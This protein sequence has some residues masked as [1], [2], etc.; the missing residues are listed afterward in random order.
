MRVAFSAAEPLM[1]CHHHPR[2]LVSAAPVVGAERRFP[3]LRKL[4]LQ[5]LLF[6]LR[7]TMV[8]AASAE[9]PVT[10]YRHRPQLLVWATLVAGAERRFQALHRLFRP[11]QAFTAREDTAQAQV[12]QAQWHFPLC[13]LRRL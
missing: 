12:P 10:S 13:P 4:C 1:S 11:L 9:D 5:P 6:K 8:V 3:V 7:G 2:L